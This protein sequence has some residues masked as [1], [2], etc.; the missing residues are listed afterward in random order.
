MPL[1]SIQ[2]A[3]DQQVPKPLTKN[4]GRRYFPDVSVAGK[5]YDSSLGVRWGLT[6]YAGVE[7][8]IE[9]C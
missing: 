5:L 1:V 2:E 8:E 9:F 3:P 4:E 7:I 6:N